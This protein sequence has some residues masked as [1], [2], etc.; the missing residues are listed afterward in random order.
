MNARAR[1]VG[2]GALQ[3][4]EQ[5]A[6]AHGELLVILVAR[7]VEEPAYV[8]GRDVLDLVDAHQRG[9]AALALDL[10]GEPLEVLVPLG[11]VREQVGRT[12]ERHRPQRAQSPPH[13]DAQARGLGRDTDEEQEERVGRHVP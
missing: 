11:G 1:G 2:L 5:L 8:F 10:L 6:V 3:V 13:P 7:L 4:L 12:L 9:L